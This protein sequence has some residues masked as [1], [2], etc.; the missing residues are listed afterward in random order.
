[1]DTQLSYGEKA[2]R[3]SFNPSSIPEVDLVKELYAKIIDLMNYL[4]ATT[5]DE[6]QKRLFSVAITE[7]QTG[8]M[9]AVDALTYQP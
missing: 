8:K 3:K 6:E 7:A 4:R 9:W 1:M 5:M 2:V